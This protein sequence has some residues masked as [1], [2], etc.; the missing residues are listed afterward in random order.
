[1]IMSYPASL[2]A[3]ALPPHDATRRTIR[4]ARQW[5]RARYAQAQTRR[6]LA[7]LT[8]PGLDSP[9]QHRTPSCFYV[10]PSFWRRL[11]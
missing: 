4:Q 3:V 1:M 2:G 10:P 6:S 11:G 7:A 9:Y 8:Q 5:F